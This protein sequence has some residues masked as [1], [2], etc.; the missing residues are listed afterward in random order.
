MWEGGSRK[1]PPYPDIWGPESDVPYQCL[2]RACRAVYHNILDFSGEFSPLLWHGR[3]RPRMTVISNNDVG[4]RLSIRDFS[5]R[6]H[7]MPSAASKL[8]ADTV[9][10]RPSS[11]QF[12][13]AGSSSQAS[14]SC[15]RLASARVCR[16]FCRAASSFA[17]MSSPVLKYTSSGVC[18]RN[19]ECGSRELCSR[20]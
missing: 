11:F 16:A 14:Q 2:I 3:W 17:G 1:A 15:F 12:R 13:L 6:F 8:A 4:E 19:A 20:T 10:R 7:S 5:R 9:T 18:P